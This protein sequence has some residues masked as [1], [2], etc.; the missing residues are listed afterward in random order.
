MVDL[1][2]LEVWFVTGSQHLYGPEV[3]KQVDKD[4]AEIAKALDKSAAIPCKVVFKP[5]LTGPD[6]ITKLCMEANTTPN[7]IG[8]MTWMHTFSPAKMWIAGLKALTKP[9]VHLHTQFNRDIPWDSID[10]DF[11]NLNQS[12]HG[13]R[14]Y[15]FIL[16]RMRK[17]RKVVVGHWKTDSVQNKLGVW[18]RAAAAWHDW[19][20]G[21]VARFGD[22]MREV[23]VTEGD[24]VE[25]QMR[26][27]Y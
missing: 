7:C 19:Q 24:K 25:A 13:G 12:A 4:S 2:Q 5:V 9:I 14:E 20:N 17:D 8:L 18:A 10:M 21:K 3:L 11:M 16:S 22:N 1:K 15:G 6:A 26:L 27:G 23:A